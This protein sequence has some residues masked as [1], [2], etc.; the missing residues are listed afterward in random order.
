M[1]H[2]YEGRIPTQKLM[3]MAAAA[4]LNNPHT[5]WLSDTGASNHITSDLANLAIHNEYHGQD[6]VAVGN[7][8]GLNIAHI[9]SNKIPYG[10]S[11]RAMNTILHCPSVAANLLSVYQFTRDN[12]CYFIFFSDCFYVKDLSMGRTLFCGKSE[13]GLYPFHIHNQIST[14][15]SHLFAFVGVRVG[16]PVWHSRL[17]HPAS[18]TLLRLIS[19]KCLPI[20]GKSSNHFCNSC[21]LGKSTKLPFHL[22][23]S[24]SKFPLELVH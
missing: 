6:Q 3:A 1:N 16:A 22:S 5:T 24:I 21:P 19:N 11:S 9:G 12:N 15:S 13:N 2:A 8:T 10:S 4:S 18:N 17:G 7:G 23:D 14:K 20:S